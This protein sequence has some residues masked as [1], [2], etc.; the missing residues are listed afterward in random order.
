M[1]LARH[2]ARFP[3]SRLGKIV[4]ATSRWRSRRKRQKS[5][6]LP[7]DPQFWSS[8][9]ASY[10]E[11]LLP[12]SYRGVNSISGRRVTA[13]EGAVLGGTG[14]GVGAG[15]GAGSGGPTMAQVLDAYRTG[16][17]HIC[18]QPCSLV[19][20]VRSRRRRRRRNRRSRRGSRISEAGA[21]SY[22]RGAEAEG[23]E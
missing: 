10:Q 3:R 21:A 5:R 6:S 7:P 15:A 19:V 20:Q 8:V 14:T 12:S 23:Q 22:N 17:L 16:I 9:M 18:E 2:L 4:L 1:I 11:I 13:G